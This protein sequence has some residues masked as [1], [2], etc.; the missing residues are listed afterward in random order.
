MKCERVQYTVH[1][2]TTN[3]NNN[4]NNNMNN[5]AAQQ[6]QQPVAGSAAQFATACICNLRIALLF[7]HVDRWFFWQFNSYQCKSVSKLLCQRNAFVICECLLLLPLLLLLLPLLLFYYC[8]K[9]LPFAGSAVA[10][11]RY[12]VGWLAGVRLTGWLVG[13][14]NAK[15]SQPITSLWHCFCGCCCN[16]SAYKGISA[17]RKSRVQQIAWGRS[18]MKIDLP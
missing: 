7:W 10:V 6:T 11:V 14:C 1:A 12:L 17:M 18:Q 15:R 13:C 8:H 16:C 3:N 9:L 2:R 4:N 5:N